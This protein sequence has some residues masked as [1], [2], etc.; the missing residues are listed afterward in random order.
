MLEEHHKSIIGPELYSD[1]LYFSGQRS[2][3]TSIYYK[4]HNEKC[5]NGFMCVPRDK[6]DTTGASNVYRCKVYN[7]KTAVCPSCQ[8]VICRVCSEK[9][10]A[11]A[12]KCPVEA[13]SSSLFHSAANKKWCAMNTC[14]CPNCKVPIEKQG[15]CNRVK[16]TRCNHYFRW[17]CK[18]ELLFAKTG[19]VLMIGGL[20]VLAPLLVV[21]ILCN[22]IVYGTEGKEGR[23]RRRR[24]HRNR[25]I[26]RM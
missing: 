3:K 14:K 26:E 10:H 19:K 21:L 6:A 18:R 11:Q 24:V 8:A 13:K 4:C 20:V 17:K 16:C 2:S 23:D 1:F 15:D 5:E 25:H 7:K 22:L 9:G 12:E